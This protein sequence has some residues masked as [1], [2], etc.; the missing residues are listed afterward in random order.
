[1]AIRADEYTHKWRARRC[2]CCCRCACRRGRGRR[3][4]RTRLRLRGPSLAAGWGGRVCVW[5]RRGTESASGRGRARGGGEG[6]LERASVRGPRRGFSEC[7]RWG[8][9]QAH[10]F[11]RALISHT[12]SLSRAPPPAQFKSYRA[13]RRIHSPATPRHLQAAPPS[14]VRLPSVLPGARCAHGVYGGKVA[15]VHRQ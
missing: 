7:G 12:L 11:A 1:M 15:L 4:A 5:R 10:E 3:C 2:C 9:P 14:T 6:E 13:A 8:R